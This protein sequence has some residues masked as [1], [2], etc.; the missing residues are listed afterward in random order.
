MTKTKTKKN[1]IQTIYEFF[2]SIISEKL[3][4]PRLQFST[5]KIESHDR[6]ELRVT[7]REK[8]SLKI[9]RTK[10]LFL[11]LFLSFLPSLFFNFHHL[12]NV[13]FSVLFRFSG[14][15]C[16]SSI[17]KGRCT[18]LL[19]QGI[20]R[21]DCCASNTAAATAYSEEDLDSGALFF[22]R[23]LGGGVPCRSCRGK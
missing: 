12:Y 6:P 21:Q 11:L 14:G 7:Y 22:W 23:V 18:E 19:A 9:E 2:F 5:L 16:W 4:Q 1:R 13:K 8:V 15:I 20:S 10:F 3:F 17:R